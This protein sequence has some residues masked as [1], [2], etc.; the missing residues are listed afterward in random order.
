MYCVDKECQWDEGVHLVLFAAHESIQEALGFSPFELVLGCTLCG[1]LKLFK[2]AWL[3][4]DTTMNLLDHVSDLH[5][6]L[7]TAT[8]LVKDNLKSAQW[9]M[10]VWYD[11]KARK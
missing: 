1:P 6:K 4:E 3:G 2:E 5:E 8:E 7:Q 10:K 11:K 9:K